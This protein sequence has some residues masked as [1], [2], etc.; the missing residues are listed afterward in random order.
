MSEM[1]GL[2]ITRRHPAIRTKEFGSGVCALLPDSARSLLPRSVLPM[3]SIVS[4]LRIPCRDSG[5]WTQFQ[6]VAGHNTRCPC[7][8]LIP[9][10]AAITIGKDPYF[11]VGRTTQAAGVNS[12]IAVFP[13]G[14]GGLFHQFLRIHDGDARRP[15][16]RSGS[17]QASLDVRRLILRGP[18]L[19]LEDVVEIP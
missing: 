11:S 9:S 8:D 3:V 17:R 7:S 12:E 19:F 5:S 15:L 1:S 16:M 14:P 2:S 10:G 13:H 18:P 4:P 6:I